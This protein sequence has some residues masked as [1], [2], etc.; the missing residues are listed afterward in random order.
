MKAY[1]I[2]ILT[3]WNN[4]V[5]YI[6]VTNSLSRRIYEHKQNFVEGFTKK[7][8]VHKL[9]YFEDTVNIESAIVREKR[10]KK[11]N[12]SWKIELIEKM[13]PEWVDLYYDIS[14]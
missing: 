10:I 13:N 2:Y 11:W 3:N 7:Y 12:R 4:K 14:F 1:W 5:L 8:H 6:G 9:V